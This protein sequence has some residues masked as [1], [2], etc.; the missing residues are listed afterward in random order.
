MNTSV[1]QGGIYVKSF[2]EGSAAEADG[3]IEV[4]DRVLEVTGVSL[5]GVT[6]KQAVETLRNTPQLCRL[7]MEKGQ[8]PPSH[9]D[10]LPSSP[11]VT[12]DTTGSPVDRPSSETMA[13]KEDNTVPMDMES[14][15]PFV[16]RGRCTANNPFYE[17]R[18]QTIFSY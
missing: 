18:K 17:S 9:K 2:N 12:S 10:R 13:L 14:Y 4:G 1:R 5:I 11:N 16:T 6:H 15:Y 8:R 7:V 3:R